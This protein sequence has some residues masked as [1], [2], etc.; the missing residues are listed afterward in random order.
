MVSS[1]NPLAI[2]SRVPPK[3]WRRFLVGRVGF[4]GDGERG[5]NVPHHNERRPPCWV[6]PSAAGHNAT[7]HCPTQRFSQ[8]KTRMAPTFGKD[9]GHQLD[10]GLRVY[11]PMRN[12]QRTCAGI[13]Q[14]TGKPDS[15]SAPGAPLALAVLQAE[16]ITASARAHD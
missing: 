7:A 12:E 8:T 5:P 2:V 6:R 10:R 15:A 9:G 14:R 11:L 4:R 1:A 16:R 3:S 13:E